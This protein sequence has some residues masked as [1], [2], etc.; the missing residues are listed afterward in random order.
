MSKRKI[1]VAV[2]MDKLNKINKDTDTT[3]ALI[4]EGI[5]RKFSIFIYNVDNLYFEN[6]ELKVLDVNV[7]SEAIYYTQ[8]EGDTLV[9]EVNFISSESMRINIEN[10]RIE[11]IK[12]NENPKKNQ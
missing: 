9:N 4:Q 8:E 12:F 3:L 10:N 1:K 5:K 2:Q 11:N 6:N 7:N